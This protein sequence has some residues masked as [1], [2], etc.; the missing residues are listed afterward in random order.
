[1][2][3]LKSHKVT[4]SDKLFLGKYKY[5]IVIRT[6]VASWFRGG[7]LDRV[8][9]C[10]ERKD[11]NY[12]SRNT[13]AADINY[14]MKVHKFLGGIET[15]NIRV[16]SPFLSIY[17]DNDEDLE[18]LV[19]LSYESI[20][21]ISIPNPDTQDKLA[22]GVVLVKNLDFG[23]KVTVGASHQNYINF[24]NWCENNPRIRLPKRTKRDLSRNSSAGGGYF[25]VKDEKNLT[26]VKMFLGRT[27]TRVETVIQG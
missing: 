27:I 2:K 21:Y 9:T 14:A 4:Y 19:K 18:D 17:L 13:T 11:E 12:Y 6:G 20:K 23:F 16:E 1:M 24:V 15:W 7:D 8:I 3:F 22:E 25:Y 5:K 26:M 10:Y